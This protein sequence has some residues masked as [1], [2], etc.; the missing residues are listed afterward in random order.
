VAGGQAALEVPQALA[1]AGDLERFHPARYVVQLLAFLE[2]QLARLFTGGRL[3][4]ALAQTAVVAAVLLVHQAVVHDHQRA[5]GHVVP[6][7]TVAADEHQ[8]P[9]VRVMGRLAFDQLPCDP[10]AVE[11]AA[12]HAG[13][14]S[15]IVS[16]RPTFPMLFPV[17][18]PERPP[19]GWAET[20]AQA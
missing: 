18:A 5:G 7:G 2:A 17:L 6:Q 10:V 9:E 19:D 8:A 14:Q 4:G 13:A 12:R 15:R 3:R 16:I 11:V 1:R 20:L